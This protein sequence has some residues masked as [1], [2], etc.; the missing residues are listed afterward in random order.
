MS[1]TERYFQADGV[2][3][4][5]VIN[6]SVA[7]QTSMQTIKIN[8]QSSPF[9]FALFIQNAFNTRR[10]ESLAFKR[11][12]STSVQIVYDAGHKGRKIDAFT[13]FSITVPSLSIKQAK[14]EMYPNSKTAL[15]IEM[16]LSDLVT[17]FASAASEFVEGVNDLDQQT[18][19]SEIKNLFSLAEEVQ[20]TNVRLYLDDEVFGGY[21]LMDIQELPHQGDIF[22]V[23]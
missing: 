12:T 13:D 9:N 11:K 8:Y 16:S 15:Q 7:E 22:Q 1:H 19:R 20:G 3:G 17:Q 21:S 4:D 2:Y 5:G 14:S 23:S 6:P 10:K 18:L